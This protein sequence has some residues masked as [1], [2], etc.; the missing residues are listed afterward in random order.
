M[1]KTGGALLISGKVCFQAKSISR[2]GKGH[3]VLIN[4]SIYQENIKILI[5]YI[6]NRVSKYMKKIWYNCKAK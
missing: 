2:D 6:C 5:D 4:G 3:L 1:K